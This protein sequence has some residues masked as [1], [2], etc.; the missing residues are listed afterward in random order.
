MIRGRR[1]RLR[2]SRGRGPRRGEHTRRDVGVVRMCLFEADFLVEVGLQHVANDGRGPGS[3]GAAFPQRSDD[4]FGSFLGGESD[5]P[6]VILHGL[7]GLGAFQ[8]GVGG[9][10]RGSGFAANLEAGDA[11]ASPG[12]AFVDDAVEAV[13]HLLNVVFVKLRYPGSWQILSVLQQVRAVPFAADGDAADV[14]GKLNGSNRGGALADGD[15]DRFTGIPFF[16]IV[17]DLPFRR[18][19]DA[20]GFMR[21]IDAGFVAEADHFGE[22]G[23]TIDAQAI[24]DVVEERVAGLNDALMQLDVSVDG[25]ALEVVAVEGGAAGAVDVEVVV[26]D[27]GLQ[28]GEGH[29]RFEGGTG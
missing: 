29:Q 27:A 22:L 6:G 16:A 26:D 8:D 3:F 15:R 23:D 13:N 14:G 20:F 4:D 10:L 25:V 17:T 18:R 24:A 5:E 9:E 2:W 28:T 12:A 11:R 19:D 7:P 21:Q 1:R